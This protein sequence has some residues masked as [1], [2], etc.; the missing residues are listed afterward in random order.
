MSIKACLNYKPLL[1]VFCF[2]RFQNVSRTLASSP[3]ILSHPSSLSSSLHHS[4]SLYKK[5]ERWNKKRVKMGGRK[6]MKE[7]FQ[8]AATMTKAALLLSEQA[9]VWFLSSFPTVQNSN[10]HSLVNDC[11][12][13]AAANTDVMLPDT[14]LLR[15]DG[16][17]GSCVSHIY[18]STSPCSKCHVRR[19]RWKC[20]L[21]FLVEKLTVSKLWYVDSILFPLSFLYIYLF[22]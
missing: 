13:T 6:M 2:L 15:E 18:T 4:L 14:D 7:Y 16:S 20:H 19:Y 22:V 11:I 17:N 21:N 9:L 3:L 1:N 5:A 10:P 12:R 8:Y